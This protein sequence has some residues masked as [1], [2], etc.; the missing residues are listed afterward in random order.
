MVLIAPNDD[1][2]FLTVLTLTESG[3]RH[4]ASSVPIQAVNDLYGVSVHLITDLED[5]IF[6][7]GLG[8]VHRVKRKL[9]WMALWLRFP[10]QIRDQDLVMFIDAVSVHFAGF[11]AEF[12]RT[13]KRVDTRKKPHRM[14]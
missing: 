4:R 7:G 13:Q 3:H 6:V 12:I 2:E 10:D 11:L 9:D 8:K 5:N 1:A 14:R